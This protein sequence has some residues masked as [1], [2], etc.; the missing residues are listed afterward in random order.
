M[1]T[2]VNSP[3]SANASGQTPD[4]VMATPLSSAEKREILSLAKQLE[5][6]TESTLTPAEFNRTYQ[7]VRVGA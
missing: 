7:R 5:K 6:T 1:E 3:L 4:A 2:P